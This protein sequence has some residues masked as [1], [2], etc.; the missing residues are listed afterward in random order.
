MTEFRETESG[1]V[2]PEPDKPKPPKRY[3]GVME[4]QDEERREMAKDALALL[5]RAMDLIRGT[6]GFP[7]LPE[8]DALPAARRKAHALALTHLGEL[9]LG[10]DFPG[11]E[12][13]T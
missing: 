7:T 1:L 8:A 3:Y 6:G 13:W 11:W 10:K 4:L 2:I 5:A 12:E 9:L